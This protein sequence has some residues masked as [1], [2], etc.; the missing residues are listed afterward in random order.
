MFGA[1]AVVAVTEEMRSAGTVETV[2][3]PARATLCAV[4][5]FRLLPV[6]LKGCTW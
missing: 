6:R 5:V 1:A 2:A 3:M 4:F